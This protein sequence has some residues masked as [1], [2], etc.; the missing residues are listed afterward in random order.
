MESTERDEMFSGTCGT[1][2]RDAVANAENQGYSGCC[3][4][5]IEYGDEALET[6]KRIA[7]EREEDER[8]EAMRTR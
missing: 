6:K 3:N 2:G 7:A 1:C 8:D 5:R 4:D